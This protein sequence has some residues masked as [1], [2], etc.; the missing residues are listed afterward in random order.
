MSIFDKENFS[1]DFSQQILPIYAFP[2]LFPEPTTLTNTL[3]T[4]SIANLTIDQ[5]R[6]LLFNVQQPFEVPMKEFDDEWWPLVTNIWIKFSYKNHVNGNS[7]KTF[8]CRFT[9]HFE[10]STRKQDIPSEKRRKTKVRTANLCF[11]KIKISRFVAEQ[12]VL[13]MKEFDDEWWPLVTNIWIKFSY[14]NHVNGNSWKTFV[15]RFTKHFE[16]STRKQDIPSEKR[17]KTKVRTANLCFAKIKISRFVAEQKVC[18][19]RF[20]DSPNHTHNIEESDKLKRS[21]AVRVLVE[22]EAVK[23]YP[24]PAIVNTVKEFGT[25]KLNL[26]LS[27]KELKWREV[28]N[29]K[30]KI[31]GSQ[32]TYLV[33]ASKLTTDIQ[34]TILF[35]KKEGYQVELY[36]THHQSTRGFV[37]AQSKQLEKL[38]RYG[39]LTLIDSTH[40]TNK[41]DWRL[42]TLYIRDGYGCWDVGAHFFVSKEDS[43]TVA[44]ALIITRRFCSSWKSR[45]FLADQSSIEAKS[46]VTAFP[47]LQKGEQKCTVIFCTVHVMRTWMSKIYDSKTR[48]EMIQAMHKRTKIGCEML[49]QESINDCALLPIKRYISRYYLKNIHQWALWARQH[50]PLLLQVTLTNALESYHSELKKMTSSQHGLIGACNKI[51][52]L[53][54]KRRSDSD[55]VAFEFRVKKISV[56]GVDDDILKEIHK[57]PLPIQKLIVNEI[58]FVNDRIEKGKELPGLTSL[59]CPL[60]FE[61][62]EID[63]I[64]KAAENRKLTVSELM[65]RTR[66]EYWN[67]K[68]NGNEKEKSEF[69]ERLKT[70]LD[71]ILKKK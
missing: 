50:S 66:N 12:K 61:I 55:Y 43:D 49:V 10:S 34:D 44:E 35:L 16:S 30:Y 22:K 17:R 48:S 9:K 20:Q 18:I 71:P 63:E 1:Q 33:G 2:Q 51:V 65:E 52:A 53:D 27:V 19:E 13:P 23:N 58:L 8:V 37:F 70:C 21:Q 57:F 14:K 46:I 7:W 45:Y 56:T 5:K 25:E 4:N 32:N 24:I 64:N 11:A 29:I 36:E 3:A 41:Y 47:G 39:W 6:T 69:M 62:R 54:L 26:G 40:K 42:F 68:E 28:A 31:H 15:C 60:S 59:E 38:Q 67:I